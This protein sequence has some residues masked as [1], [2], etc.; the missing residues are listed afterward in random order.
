M[1][2]FE[3][4]FYAGEFR[5]NLDAKKRLTIPSKW[6]FNG[7]EDALYLALPDPSGCITV[8]PPEMVARFKEMLSQVSM[9][10][11]AGQRA[12]TAIMSKAETCTIDKSGRINLNDRLFAHAGVD[13]TCV[14]VGTVN[15]FSIWDP[16][17]YE[18]YLA[19]SDDDGDVAE[20]L[21]QLGL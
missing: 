19:G 18:A 6:R 20:I 7:D 17:R 5:H 16:E 4:G 1:V 14:L 11:R 10:N 21:G 9:G 8:Y 2:S 3:Q 13:K 15:K 12:I